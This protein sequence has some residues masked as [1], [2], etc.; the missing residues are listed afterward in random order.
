MSLAKRAVQ[1]DHDRQRQTY[2]IESF[3]MEVPDVQLTDW[4]H[5]I[6]G[7]LRPGLFGFL[8]LGSTPTVVFEVVGTK[9]GLTHY[10]HVPWRHE[11]V[12]KQLQSHMPG[13]RIV[14][15]TKP[16][17]H[18]WKQAVEIGVSHTAR[19][20]GIRSPEQM[21][22]TI[23]TSMQHLKGN[24]RVLM[25]WVVTPAIRTELPE[26]D[27]AKTSQPKVAQVLSGNLQA[28]R[29]EID[30]RRKKLEEPNLLAVLRVAADADT[31]VHAEHLLD[32]L[33]KAVTSARG[34]RA[35]FVK[36]LMSSERVAK[37]IEQGHTPFTFPIKLSLSELSALIGW[38]I[39]SSLTP[40]IATSMSRH[41]PPSPIILAR[42]RILGKANMPGN[43]RAVA[44]SYASAVR[45]TYLIGATGMG[46]TTLLVNTAVQDMKAGHG[47][48]IIEAK[49]DLFKLTLERIPAD[50]VDDV[51]ILDVNDM[52]SPVGFNIFDQG[53]SRTAID[54]LCLLIGNMYR[55][56]SQSITAPQM[57]YHFT[58]ALAEVPG[59][60]FMDLPILMSP[61][62]IQ[63]P[64]AAFRDAIAR[65]VKN[66]QV[67]NYLQGFLNL[68][69]A[70]QN[71]LAAPLYNRTWEF[72]SRPEIR[73]ILGQRQSSFKMRDVIEQN[74]IL[75]VSLSGARV[76]TQ[77]ANLAG[78]LLVNAIWQAVRSVTPEK[79]N[80][81]YLDEFSSF[82]KLPVDIQSILSKSRSANLGMI[83]AHQD[84][85]E[86]SPQ[87]RYSVMSNVAT[88]IAF[89][90]GYQ[91]ANEL[92]RQFGPFVTEADFTG[93]PPHEAI[94]LVGLDSNSAPPVTIAT[95][96]LPKLLKGDD[97]AGSVRY[98]SR[99][100]YGRPIRDVERELVSYGLPEHTTPPKRSKPQIS[101]G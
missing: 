68:A 5:A 32:D 36:R 38:P 74:K 47:V 12:I 1:A 89:K 18:G 66:P 60:T 48:I 77:T 59:T 7:T 100:T 83:L 55:D 81:L 13:I 27:Q 54:E 44:V 67:A 46:K 22:T 24:E 3:P 87:F 62:S 23:R 35:Y 86:M 92:A 65:Q 25:Q 98:K 8:H 31:N 20:L 78:T 10:L 91:E 33:R 43:E 58:H 53:N 50:R 71:R 52:D 82:M 6:S 17:K 51:I 39:G 88:K 72:M 95:K 14:R 45:H 16:L 9:A 2:R 4:L 21:W 90:V 80:F 70:E 94:A 28:S 34:T 97:T 57:L 37:R 99:Q 73:V 84:F 85:S 29:D 56:S 11:Y 15:E 101:G 63:T 75:L 93:L 61:A 49:D 79:P 30:E 41:L 96:P 19:Q 26:H 64:E 69:P 76:G 40:G 42:G